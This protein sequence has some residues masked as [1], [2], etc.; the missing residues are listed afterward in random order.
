MNYR[1]YTHTE[2]QPDAGIIKPPQPPD[3]WDAYT[4]QDT[5]FLQ[6]W[7]HIVARYAEYTFYICNENDTL[8][9]SGTA[10]PLH[11]SAPL[12]SLPDGGWRWVISQAATN[13][14]PP[15]MLCALGIHIEKPYRGHGLTRLA[16]QTIHDLAAQHGFTQLIVPVRPSQKANFPLIPMRDYITWQREDGLLYD[17]WMRAHQHTGAR[18]LHVAAASMVVRGTVAQW[19]AW[20]GGEFPGD[21]QYIVPGGL[22]PMTVT[23]GEGVYEE[24]NVWM[25][26]DVTEQ[27]P[28]SR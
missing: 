3:V 19:V 23:N 15:T 17:A 12:D 1:L 26:H 27:Q 25:V 18:V 16:L 22:V 8:M 28:A 7:D 10:V 5:V 13:D 6:Y 4:L 2:R 14:Q 11:Y 21:G 24:P 20:T 9:L